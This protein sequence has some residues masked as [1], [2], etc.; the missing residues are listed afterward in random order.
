MKFTVRRAYVSTSATTTL[1]VRR[2]VTLVVYISFPLAN[3]HWPFL[4][5][6]RG[7]LNKDAALFTMHNIC[8]IIKQAHSQRIAEI[9]NL[10]VIQLSLDCSTGIRGGFI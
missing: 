7:P 4:Y 8:V 1:L 3:F 5:E 6:A 9:I 10:I 2:T